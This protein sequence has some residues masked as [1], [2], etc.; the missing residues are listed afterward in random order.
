MT[1]VI[2]QIF[3]IIQ[4]I[5][6]IA[7][8]QIKSKNKIIIFN[9]IACFSSAMSFLLLSA[10]SGCVMSLLG[11]LRNYLFKDD[12]EKDINKLLIIIIMLI[13]FTIFTYDGIFS[14]MP[15]IATLLYT[16]SIWQNNTKVYRIMGLPI[17]ISWLIYHIHV[18]SI[19]GIILESFLLLS[20]VIGII[21]G[22][23][24]KS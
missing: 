6:L 2:S 5:F 19:F 12:K 8:Y 23:K 1:Y 11:V 13:L 17:E 9:I 20:V 16:L 14:L 10:F 18:C 15:S 7:T 22:F 3:V 21:K 4:Y 24:K